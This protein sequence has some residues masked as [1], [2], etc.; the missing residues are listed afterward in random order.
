MGVGRGLIPF[1]SKVG[2]S[3]LYK[4]SNARAETLH[5]KRSFRDLVPRKRCVVVVEG[6]FEWATSTPSPGVMAKQPYFFQ[7]PGRKPLALAALYDCWRDAQGAC[8]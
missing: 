3:R 7:R 4:T 1:W 8:T 6:Y 5:A 2:D